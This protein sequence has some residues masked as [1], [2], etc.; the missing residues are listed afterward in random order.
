MPDVETTCCI[1]GGGPAGIMLGYL[2]A[3]AGVDVVVL[4]KHAD[5]FRDFRGDTVHPSTLNV[6]DE[7]GLLDG[8][9]QLKHTEVRQA[10]GVVGGQ[11]LNVV[12]FSMVPG[13]CKFLMFMAQ[14]D[15]LN[16]LA[17]NARKFPSFHLMMNAEAIEL[18]HEGDHVS[19]VIVKTE[20]GTQT[21]RARLVVAADGRHS[22]LRERAGLQVIERGAPIDVLW[23]RIS[24]R[25]DDPV[26]S[27]GY[28]AQGA[29]LVAIDRGEYYQ[30][31]FVIK[32]GGFE[33]MQARGLD[34][35]RSEITRLAP[36]MSDR[37]SEIATWDDVKLLTVQVDHLKHWWRPGLL[38]IGD[39]AHAMSPIGGV[40]INLAIQ[41]AIAAANLLTQAL[42]DGA[43]TDDD[44]RA[45]QAR[46]EMPTQR[47]QGL[48]VLIQERLMAG[49]LGGAKPVT[50]PWWLRLVMSF[51][52]VRW[53][54]AYVLGVGF[55]PEHV[56]SFS[57]R[58]IL[59][60]NTPHS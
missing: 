2:L 47:T 14:W 10:S 16:F 25:A 17:Q 54:P 8:L 7:L 12:D 55:R 49:I 38:C 20:A 44:L 53:I 22:I 31:A 19:G 41:D 15:F 51:R 42:S 43:V 23:M 4:E 39:A 56:R 34:F 26:Q 9:L 36:F 3:R 58:P 35:L 30:C 13:R 60:T 11:P 5:F 21:V 46:R 37:V 27:V 48:Q 52:P 18:T 24:R 33:E 45:V 50:A 32:K 6:M 40:G 1:A 29:L 57:R 59:H 28:I